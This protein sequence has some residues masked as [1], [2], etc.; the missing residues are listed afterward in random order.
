MEHSLCQQLVSIVSVKHLTLCVHLCYK[1]YNFSGKSSL[2]SKLAFKAKTSATD[3]PE[4]GKT[5]VPDTPVENK[6]GT[7]EE[8]I[9]L[10]Q[11]HVIY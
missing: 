1:Y 3:T 6:V 5:I 8:G 7:V 4:K 10:M 9:L 2:A 11:R